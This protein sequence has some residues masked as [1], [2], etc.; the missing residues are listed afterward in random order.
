MSIFYKGKQ[1]AGNEVTLSEVKNQSK[2][3]VKILQKEGANQ[4][5]IVS[6][7]VEEAVGVAIGTYLDIASNSTYTPSGYLLRDGAEYNK[8]QFE[9]FYSN[10]LG[11]GNF[12]TTT[13]SWT[14]VPINSTYVW[15]D[16]AYGNNRFVAVG[17]QISTSTDGITWE[18]PVIITDRFFYSVCYGNGRFIAVGRDGYITYSTDGKNWATPFTVGS[19]HWQSVCYG[20]GK[21]V[22]MGIN[23]CSTSVDGKTWTTPSKVITDGTET[24]YDVYYDII[25]ANNKFMAV[26]YNAKVTTSIDGINWSTPI[27]IDPKYTRLGIAYGNGRYVAVG[28]QIST[29]TDGIT[30]EEPIQIL[31]PT[32]VLQS[33]VYGDNKFIAVGHDGYIVT[34]TNGINWEEPIQILDPTASYDHQQTLEGV[35]YGKNKFVTVRLNEFLYKLKD[36]IISVGLIPYTTYIDYNNQVNTNGFCD[37]FAVDT[38]NQKFRTPLANPNNRVL[39]EKKEPTE[40]DPTWYNL[41]NDGWCEQGGSIVYGAVS[42]YIITYPIEM[43]DTNYTAIITPIDGGTDDTDGIAEDRVL[44]NGANTGSYPYG[45]TTTQLRL[46]TYSSATSGVDWTVKGYTNQVVEGST[47]PYVVVANGELNESD[48]NWSQW[49]TSLEGKVD[50]GDMIPCATIIE[51]Y[52]SGTEGYILYSNNYCEQWGKV[53]RTAASQAITLFKPY[54]DVNYGIVLQAYHTALSTDGRPP[55]VYN[56]DTAPDSFTINL[57]TGYTGVYWRTYGFIQG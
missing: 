18:E 22:A 20:N 55:L 38:E 28:G 31:D 44:I 42:S 41:Y 36:E 11:S 34:S 12:N 39:I 14:S 13:H 40:A 33:I 23:F 45:K 52:E 5:T 25:Y 24:E 57:Y 48:M 50:K 17:G 29:S 1:I 26:S 19:T 43:T 27:S 2:E 53:G 46:S 32:I 35:C 47:R 6:K 16:I 8:S 51:W 49:A 30:W 37:L 54:R 56:A 4:L 10:W 9:S 21:Y 3:E 7:K 15:E